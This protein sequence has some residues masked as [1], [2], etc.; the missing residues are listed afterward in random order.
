MFKDLEIGDHCGICTFVFTLTLKSDEWCFLDCSVPIG[1]KYYTW[2]VR[3]LSFIFQFKRNWLHPVSYSERNLKEDSVVDTRGQ[4]YTCLTYLAKSL[5]CSEDPHTTFLTHVAESHQYQLSYF[6]FNRYGNQWLIREMLTTNYWTK[7]TQSF[8]ADVI[9]SA[10][11]VRS[12]MML[13]K[14][15]KIVLRYEQNSH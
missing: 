10:A 13:R 6:S 7:F 4:W 14:F 3:L 11:F 12:H 8:L 1:R 2:N 9:F 15:L 5:Q